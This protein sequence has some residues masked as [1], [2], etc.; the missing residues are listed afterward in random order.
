MQSL[1]S[2]QQIHLPPWSGS[3]A[4]TTGRSMRCTQGWARSQ[5][6]GLPRSFRGRW[7][8]LPLPGMA[9]GVQSH[10]IS[11]T[12]LLAPRTNFSPNGENCTLMMGKMK[13]YTECSLSE[14]PGNQ[15]C[16]RILFSALGVLSLEYW[17]LGDGPKSKKKIYVSP[18]LCR[19]SL[20][21]NLYHIYIYS[22][23]VCV[24]LGLTENHCTKSGVE[25]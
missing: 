4:E 19:D 17:D 11:C 23:C 2:K 15:K 20:E 24:C 5:L 8:S 18:I 6:S 9:C 3:Q 10:P 22:V 21:D 25:F 14:V 7:E 1:P 13:I 12:Q 16:L